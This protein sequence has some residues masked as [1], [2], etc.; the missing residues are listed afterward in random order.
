I[1][2]AVVVAG[3]VGASVDWTWEIPAVFGP[4]VV[5]AALLLASASSRQLARNGYWIGLGTVAAAW[6]AIIAGG[7]VV[8]TE[9]DLRQSRSAAAA[10]KVDQ[11]IAHAR[12]ARTVQPWSA[13]PYTQLA[14]L[15]EERGDYDQAIAYLKQAEERD[16]GDWRLPLIEFRLEGRRGDTA[17]A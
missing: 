10:G 1:L 16:S 15:E 11:A 4:A 8:L 14:L 6:V 2:S 13:E 12:A 5:C 7:L 17:A 9:P 3:A